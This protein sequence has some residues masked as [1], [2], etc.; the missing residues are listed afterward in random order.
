VL[1]PGGAAH[2][3]ALGGLDEVERFLTE[4][5]KH[6]KV[7]GVL[8]E[9]F[10]LLPPAVSGSGVIVSDTFTDAFIV[11]LGEHRFPDREGP[12]GGM[13]GRRRPRNA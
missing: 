8:G 13:G 4:A 12:R 9:A 6:G 5:F 3:E 11:A 2:V 10:Q 7:I 1:V